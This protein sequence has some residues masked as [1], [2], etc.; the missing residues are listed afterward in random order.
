MSFQVSPGVNI[1]EIDLT[2][3]VPAVSTSTGAIA[4]LMNWGPVNQRIMVDS[5]KY[6]ASRFG[7]PSNLNAETWFTAASFL[8]YGNSL[9]VV[10]AAPTDVF[11]AYANTGAATANLTNTIY[12]ETDYN[13][14]ATGLDV[15]IT[16]L[17]KYPGSF[18]NSL[19]ISV[20][21][22]PT[23]YNSVIDMSVAANTLATGNVTIAVGSNTATVTISNTATGNTTQM[24]ALAT[25]LLAQISVDDLVQVGNAN[26]GV[27]NLK[28]SSTSGS[29]TS[30]STAATFTISFTDKLQLASNVSQTNIPRYWEFYNLVNGAPGTSTY[31]QQ[32]GNTAA[33]DEMHVVVVDQGGKFTGVPGTILETY[34]GLSRATDAKTLDGGTNYYK[35]IINQSSQYIWWA[36]DRTSAVSNT[37]VNLTSASNSAIMDLRFVGGS[38]GASTEANVSI[39]TIT[40]GYDYYAS[41]ED[42]DISLLLTGKALGGTYGEQLPNYL[43]DNIALK[44]LDCVVFVSPGKATV[45]NNVGYEASSMVAFRNNSRDTSY[46]V[47]DSGYKYMYDR[48]NDINR[49]IPLNG[50]IAGLCARTDNSLDPWWSPAGF[51]RGQIKNIIKLAYNPRHTD[52]DTLYKAGINP[53]VTFP[54]QGTILYG[55]KTMQSKPSAFDRINVRRLFIVLEKSIST[56]AKYTLF[57]FNDQFTRSQFKNLVTPFLRTVKGRR[58]ITDFLVVCDGTNN[59][60]QIVDSNQFVGDIYIKPARSINFIQLNFVAVGTGVQFAEIVGQF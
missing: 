22:S 1:T 19:R 57:E 51:N 48:Y 6:L 56:A 58:G 17:A 54:G 33:K 9:Y 39:A 4:G 11:S 60:P 55:D 7:T 25:S 14:R 20:C 23:A 44:R 40:A 53:V 18:G 26:V 31:Q 21:D 59:T 34:A 3:I 46:A 41:A 32:F 47:L 24:T 15:D 36:N 12:N 2:T 5:E 50:D 16:Y 13:N 35:N 37:A 52:R 49:W 10:R 38:D 30:N 42:V 28:I 29:V 43:I 27:Q 8:G 45:V